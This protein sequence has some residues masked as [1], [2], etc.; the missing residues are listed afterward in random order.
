MQSSVRLLHAYQRYFSAIPDERERCN[1]PGERRV[2]GVRPRGR[3]LSAPWHPGQHR[4][5]AVDD[6]NTPG[7]WHGPVIWYFP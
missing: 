5:P 3:A 7:A 2:G 1:Q 4:Q 6:R